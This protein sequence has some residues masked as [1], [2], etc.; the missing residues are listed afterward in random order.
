MTQSLTGRIAILWSQKSRGESSSRDSISL[1]RRDRTGIAARLTISVMAIVIVLVLSFCLAPMPTREVKTL[2]PVLPYIIYGY[3]FDE[4][5]GRLSSCTLKVLDCCSMNSSM[6]SSDS[7]GK[8]QFDLSSL[9]GAYQMGDAI[10]L[11][12]NKTTE[13]GLNKTTVMSSGGKWLNLTLS[14][15]TPIRIDSNSEFDAM[16]GVSGGSGTAADPYIIEDR[17]ISGSGSGYCIFI[18]NTTA[19]FVVKDCTLTNAVFD[20]SPYRKFALTILNA[21]N[22][23]VQSNDVS[24]SHRGIGLTNGTMHCDVLDNK[25]YSN[26]IDGMYLSNSNGNALSD[27]I[28][29]SNGL[30]GIC[31][32]NSTGNTISNNTVSNNTE[33][34]VSILGAVSSNNRVWNNTFYHNN[35]TG[36]AYDPSHI[37]AYDA[38]TNNRWNTSGTPHGCGNYWSD[39]THPDSNGDGIVDLPYVFASNQD[40]YPLAHYPWEYNFVLHVLRGWNLVTVPPIGYGYKAS[41][42]G[43]NQSDAVS[44]FNPATGLYQTYIV[45]GPPPKDFVIAQSTGYWI[46]ATLNETLCLYGIIPTTAQSRS[47]TLPASGGWFIVGFNTLNTTMKASNIAA[48]YSGGAVKT[49]ASYDAVNRTYKSYIVGGPP[50]K[51]FA[52]VPGHAY[53]V[54]ATASGTLTYDP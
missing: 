2:G 46:Y 4:S 6:T 20:F 5:G 48:M 19:H 44:G 51:D 40:N 26:S 37:Q 54:Y 3:T 11:L 10:W 52:L 42:L 21:T 27:N 29:S 36:D 49:I 30:R 25:V 32:D 7:E 1:S 45:G 24:N 33:Y 22:G 47:I 18:G 35:G 13:I 17:S 23:L 39:W 28:C 41:T 8:Y 31:L 34:G 50:T 9:P 14:S 43:L 53:W 12:G 15:H 38:G 16:H